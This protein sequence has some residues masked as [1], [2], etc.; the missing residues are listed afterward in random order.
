MHLH[1]GIM[2]SY[3]TQMQVFTKIRLFC[4]GKVTRLIIQRS[5]YGQAG[6]PPGH[7]PYTAQ[8]NKVF[9]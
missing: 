6:L 5:F 7:R 3:C 1:F 4:L 2:S 8:K 9:H